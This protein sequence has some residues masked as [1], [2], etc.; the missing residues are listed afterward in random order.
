MT[1]VSTLLTKEDLYDEA[2]LW[3]AKMDR[4]LSAVEEQELKKWIAQSDTNRDV[5]FGMAEQWDK[6]DE[7]SCLSD[8][9]SHATA[10]NL[11]WNNWRTTA[12]AASVTLVVLLGALN[13]ILPITGIESVS[14]ILAGTDASLGS[15][16]E[17]L[18]Y[19]TAI[20]EQS[21]VVLSDGTEV[22][23]NTNTRISV[24]YSEQERLINL[25][26]GELHVEVAH[27][28]LRPLRVVANDRIVEAIGTAFN[29]RRTDGMTIELLVTDGRVR[30][31]ALD[32]APY[33]E[34]L[35]AQVTHQSPSGDESFAVSAGEEIV[36]GSAEEVL[37]SIAPEDIAIKLS[38]REGNLTFQGET[39]EEAMAEVGRYT[40]T[41]FI[42][43]DES[44]KAIRVAGRFKAGDMNALLSTLQDSFNITYHQV[45]ENRIELS[46]R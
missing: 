34:A 31:S 46:A 22:L 29:M 3:I 14:S 24:A 1:K 5:L 12:I 43:L 36:L 41:Q 6:M 32:L 28:P 17:T 13:L 16:M 10:K 25:E 37:Q 23:L 42:F 8:I 30:V 27:N 19:E 20:G 15:E 33:P 44:A 11:T 26:R 38:W 7:L 45:D 4:K 39:L 2:S 18:S 21:T 9:F 40:S 35:V